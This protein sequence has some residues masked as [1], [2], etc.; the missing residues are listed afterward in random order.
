MMHVPDMTPER[1]PA[2]APR[3]GAVTFC[4]TRWSLVG[5]AQQ[6]S[7]EGRHA[8]RDLC[9]AYYEPVNA[10]LRCQ[11]LEADAARELAHEFFASLLAGDAVLHAAQVRGRFRAYL[12]GAVQHFLSHH[13]TAARRLKRGGGAV[14]VPLEDAEGGALSVADPHGLPPDAA[15]DRQWALTVLA[16][17]MAALHS[18]CTAQ[19][20]AGFLE[21]VK[22]WLMGEAAYGDQ[23]A[24]AARCGLEEQALKA[25]VYRLKRRFRHLVKEEI[26]STLED[27]GQVDAELRDL[28]A[29]LAG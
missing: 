22:P 24:L 20:R 19:G 21:Q 18:E 25:A 11:G 8:L 12:L 29:A 16:R 10:W 9:H 7:D 5:R 27:A 23:A 14:C 1:S 13:R 28:Y 2:A 17:A 4:T 6:P 26:A 3:R 15:F